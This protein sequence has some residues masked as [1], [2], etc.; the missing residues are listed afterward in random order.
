LL[1]GLP[2]YHLCVYI[3]IHL[4]NIYLHL[5]P[6]IKQH[7]CPPVQSRYPNIPEGSCAHISP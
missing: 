6:S 7:L 5:F 1:R 2:E 3:Y 4:Y